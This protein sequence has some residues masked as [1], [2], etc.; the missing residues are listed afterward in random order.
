MRLLMRRASGA[1]PQPRVK[2]VPVVQ[3]HTTNSRHVPRL[4][5]K[6]SKPHPTALSL[7]YPY[8]YFLTESRRASQYLPRAKQHVVH[9]RRNLIKPYSALRGGANHRDADG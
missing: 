9:A 4:T 8:D 6:H 1:E 2:G 5:Q 7:Q 3:Y